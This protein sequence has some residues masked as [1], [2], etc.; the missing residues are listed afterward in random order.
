MLIWNWWFSR[1]EPLPPKII[2]YR[3]YKN[4]D[5]NEFRF[6]FKKHLNEFNADDITV[7][8]FK[9]TFLNVL[10]KFASLKKK[11]LRAN[12][13]H[14]VNKELNKVIMQRSR[15]SNVYL[16]DKTRAARIAYKKQR[17]MCII[18][19]KS[20]M[21]YYENFDTKNITD[22]KTFW[23]TMKPLS[24]N[25]VRRNTY[26]EWRRKINKKLIPDSQYFSHIFYWN[27]SEPW[28]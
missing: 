15:L 28:H 6:L 10:N 22:N 3:N 4:F 26:I 7:D 20:K 11:Y 8:I 16:K 23:G 18:L 9:M 2:K 14:F 17:N 24:S 27:C 1:F 5:E 13:S 12:H 21:C 19:R 25:K